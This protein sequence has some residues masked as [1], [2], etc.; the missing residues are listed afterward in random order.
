GEI[1]AQD[2]GGPACIRIA[3]GKEN[4][5]I[6]DQ[7]ELHEL[8]PRTA[9]YLRRIC[10][11]FGRL[12]PYRRHGVHGGEIAEEN[13]RFQIRLVAHLAVADDDASVGAGS[14]LPLKHCCCSSVPLP[15]PPQPP[16][17]PPPP[18]T[19]PPTPPPAPP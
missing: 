7:S 19:H 15:S 12:G 14:Q 2:L 3:G 4:C 1:I 9:Q 6:H 17:T 8:V 11:L 16:P 13:H 5:R 18:P 10:G